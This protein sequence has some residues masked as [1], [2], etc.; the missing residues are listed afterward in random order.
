MPPK[1]GLI[2][3]DDEDC[4][5]VSMTW[6]EG[7]GGTICHSSGAKMSPDSGIEVDGKTYQLNKSDLQIEKRLGQGAGGVVSLATHKPTGQKL[8]VKQMKVGT[9]ELKVQMLAEIKALIEAEGC[10][11]LVQWYAGYVDDQSVTIGLE[12]MD[13][14]CLSDLKKKQPTG[15]PPRIIA[16]IT[17][18]VLLGLHHIHGFQ[19]LH[20]DIKLENI[21]HNSDG[22][23]KLTD[24]GISK[25]IDNTAGAANTQIGTNLYMS[26]ERCE[27]RQYGFVA[28]TWS[29]GV[30][31]YELA[32]GQNP[33]STVGKSFPKLWA[34][35]CEEPEPR[36]ERLP[37]PPGGPYPEDLCDFVA[38][39]LEREEKDRWDSAKLLSRPFVTN[40]DVASQ[41]EFAEF[42][43]TL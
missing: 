43:K 19:K 36:L 32:C 35:L 40:D 22:E 1:F 2:L 29:V 34:A 6:K 20:R 16:C 42:L 13:R 17:K 24:F 4:P 21:L 15:L 31:V 12:Y 10:P 39:T 18:Q 28:D 37:Q 25:D 33:F 41:E 30:V 26:P 3:D 23:V 9:K 7:A 5:S 27:G 11:N 8:A 38:K 14:G